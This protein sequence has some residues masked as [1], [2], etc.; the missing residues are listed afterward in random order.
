MRCFTYAFLALN[1]ISFSNCAGFDDYMSFLCGI[2]GSG[3]VVLNY[4]SKTC[5]VDYNSTISGAD[6]NLPSI[7]IA[8]LNQSRMLQRTVINVA[9]DESYSVGWTA[10]Y[11]VSMKVA[12]THFF[13]ASGASQVLNIILNVTMNNSSASF[14]RIGLLGN[15]GHSVNIPVSV[16]LKTSYNSNTTNVRT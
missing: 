8:K 16:I 12:P 11:G 6:L 3:P 2:N 1:G 7:T 14:G 4:T 5:G 10:P 15:Q 13:I 9:G